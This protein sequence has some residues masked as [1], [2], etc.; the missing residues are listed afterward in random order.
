MEIE[1]VVYSRVQRPLPAYTDQRE[2]SILPPVA[3]AA[4]AEDEVEI[5]GRA[6]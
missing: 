4:N 1:R 6:I 5:I 3:V 2:A